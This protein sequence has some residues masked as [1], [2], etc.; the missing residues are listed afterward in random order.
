MRIFL[1]YASEDRPRVEPI[2]YALAEQGHDV[3]FDRED[4]LPGE[5]FD[6]RIRNA[7]EC[8]DLF[9]C[10]LTPHT[11]DAGSYT[12]SELQVAERMW[13]HASGRVLPVVL[14]DVPRADIPA[15][16]RSV[17]L[18]RPV[19]NITA[20]VADAVHQL[21]R[22]H[23]RRRVRRIS[24]WAVAILAP[25]AIALYW[26]IQRSSISSKDGAPLV[27]I[28][29]GVFTMGDDENSPMRELYVSAF[30]IDRY[31][32]TTARYAR[33]LAENGSLQPPPE[34]ES[35]DVGTQGELPVVGVSWRDAHAY[36]RWAGKRLP[37]EAEW[38]KAA[39][40]GDARTYPWGNDA[41]RPE[42]AAFGR[43]AENAYQGG[44]APVGTHQAGRS[45][46]GVDD[47]AGNVSE[48]VND[49][50]SDSFMRDDVRDPSGPADGS[51]RVIR[52]STWREPAGKL[53]AA[54]RYFASEDHRSD[55]NG[56]RCARD[57]QR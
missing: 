55:D 27:L 16:L 30:Y 48:W 44:L 12:L 3:F 25:L 22:S 17:T 31:E 45:R 54:R 15:Y 36:C 8:C 23:R 37:T 32:V 21:A 38:E 10:F 47:L 52:G 1:S 42:S 4:L 26:F 39:R 29:G 53:A 5:A 33:F 49:W 34:W 14:D 13:P 9:I 28:E 56:F 35:V 6:S 18:L 50:H 7:I 57:A 24:L 19:G 2:R 46:E 51:H 20:S 11:V 43:D 41:P 40:D